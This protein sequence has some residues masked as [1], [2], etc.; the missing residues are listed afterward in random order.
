MLNFSGRTKEL[1]HKKIT[2]FL[3][4]IEGVRKI[5]DQILYSGNISGKNFSFPV[6]LDRKGTFL[7][8]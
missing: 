3:Q 1:G 8:E 7:L 6:V 4:Q 5:G 2:V